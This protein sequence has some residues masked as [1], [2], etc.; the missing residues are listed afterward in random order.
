MA[1][2]RTT[3][4]NRLT[5]RRRWSFAD[6]VFDE[7]NWALFVAG[8]RVPVEIKPL[9]LLRELLLNAGSLVSKE[10]LLNAIWPDTMVVEA[11]L[12]T[13]VRKLRCALNDDGRATHMIETVPRIGY[14][15][16]ATVRMDEVVGPAEGEIPPVRPANDDRKASAESALPLR[17]PR[18]MGRLGLLALSA[19]LV[20]VIGATAMTLASSREGPAITAPTAF[21]QQDARNAIRRLDVGAIER[22]LAAGWNPN[23]EI[24]ADGN[25]ALHYVMEICEWNPVADRSRLLLM[26]RTIYEG[27]GRLDQ[28]NIWGDTPYSIARSPRYCGPDHPV[29]RSLQATCSE[30]GVVRD[31]C[32]ASYEIA[33]RHRG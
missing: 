9:E 28:R 6:C 13:A 31:G 8:A 21:S 10:D 26:T 16:A 2:P 18:R 1:E 15:L 22:M 32:L 23:V 29:T 27:G 7:G 17:S 4:G 5:R 3:E 20:L 30:H 11:S 14:R 19:G 25:A 12:P 33:R 24:S